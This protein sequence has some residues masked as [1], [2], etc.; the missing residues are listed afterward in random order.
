MKEELFKDI[1]EGDNVTK[2]KN[3]VCEALKN[4]MP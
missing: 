2:L 3:E 4:I 1:I